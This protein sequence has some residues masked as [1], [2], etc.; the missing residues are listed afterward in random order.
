MMIDVALYVSSGGLSLCAWRDTVYD[1]IFGDFPAKNT[2]YT[3]YTVGSRSLRKL[4]NYLAKKR[5][6]LI[7][8]GALS[9]LNSK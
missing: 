2:V 9:E 1:R 3:P 6:F 5:K 8:L 7:I 4:N